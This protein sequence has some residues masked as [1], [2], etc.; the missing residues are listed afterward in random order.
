L[1]LGSLLPLV[2]YGMAR[3]ASLSRRIALWAGLIAAVS[4]MGVLASLLAIT[5]VG[6]VLA[7]TFACYPLLRAVATHTPCRYWQVGLAI[8]AGALFKWPIYILWLVIIAAIPFFPALRTKQFFCGL[9]IS[10]LGLVPV[11]I[12]NYQHDWMTFRHVGAT[13]IGRHSAE[14]GTTGLLH[15]NVFDFIGAQIVLLSPVFFIMLL[16]ACKHVWQQRHC[17]KMPASILICCGSTASILGIYT[18]IACFQKMQG[19]WCIFTY[20]LAFVAVAWYGCECIHKGQRWLTAG[21]ALAIAIDITAL[22]L[23]TC[24]VP[25]R[26]H[27]FKYNLGWSSIASALKKGGYSSTG[28]F[29][30][31]D[32]YQ[33]TSLLSFYGPDQQRAYFLNLQGMRDNQFT[34]WPSLAQ[35]QLGRDGFFIWIDIPRTAQAHSEKASLYQQMLVPYF[36]SVR[37]VDSYSLVQC[38]TEP[39]KILSV[40]YAK[41]YN[42][43][44]PAVKALY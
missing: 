28:H 33:T 35:E 15:G 7:W 34:Q 27:P 41:G 38:G 43:N 17:A 25:L 37:F 42:G 32:T 29:L 39:A 14:T 12:W 40:W 1:L 31:A 13:M 44:I 6:M 10:L 8:A 20:P 2:V 23:P 36:Q 19:N 11:F 26:M 5:D 16:L 18:A 24:S 30:C 4:P 21:L 3:Y 9:G 22:I